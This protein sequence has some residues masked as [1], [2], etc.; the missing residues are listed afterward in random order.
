MGVT[1]SILRFLQRSDSVI[2]PV[3]SF[4]FV[5]GRVGYQGMGL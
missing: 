1:S 2:G 3:G 4:R 5:F